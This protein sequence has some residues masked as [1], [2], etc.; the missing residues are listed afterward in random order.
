MGAPTVLLGG[1]PAARMGDMTAH[2]GVISLGCFTV[3]IGTAGS[4]SEGACPPGTCMTAVTELQR[5]LTLGLVIPAEEVNA[6]IGLVESHRGGDIPEYLAVGM[7]E[8]ADRLLSGDLY[9][10]D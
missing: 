1:R 8:N 2:G 7:L 10:E 3:L 4:T 9:P 5:L 6:F